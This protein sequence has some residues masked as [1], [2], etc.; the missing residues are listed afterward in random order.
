MAKLA[1]GSFYLVQ[2]EADEPADGT[3]TRLRM[4]WA[5]SDLLQDRP[6]LSR[7]GPLK[8]DFDKFMAEGMAGKSRL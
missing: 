4:T 8:D 5:T 2:P 6:P 7:Y 1:T 3:K